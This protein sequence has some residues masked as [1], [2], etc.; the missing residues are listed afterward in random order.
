ML[1]LKDWVFSFCVIAASTVALFIGLNVFC[2]WLFLQ[3]PSL[4]QMPAERIAQEAN[5]RVRNSRSANAVK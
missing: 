2:A 5:E 1:K 4:L 3:F